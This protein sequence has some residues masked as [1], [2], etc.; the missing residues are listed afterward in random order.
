MRG[1]VHNYSERELKSAIV[2]ISAAITCFFQARRLI[3]DRLASLLSFKTITQ[4][5]SVS[6]RSR[7]SGSENY[8]N[9]DYDRYHSDHPAADK[10]VS[11]NQALTSILDL[12]ETRISM[13]DEERQRSDSSAKVKRDWMLA[14][15]VLDR[16]CFIALFVLFTGGTL[17]FIVLL[18]RS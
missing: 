1:T 18:A 10:N 12:L 3:C 13:D 9:G 17:V 2:F 16:L 8:R 4:P 15:A 14:A 7:Q 5:L 6:G 11:D